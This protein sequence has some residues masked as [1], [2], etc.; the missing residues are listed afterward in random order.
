[1]SLVGKEEQ[2]P[3]HGGDYNEEAPEDMRGEHRG[4]RKSAE[5]KSSVYRLCVRVVCSEIKK[6]TPGSVVDL[7]L[8][9]KGGR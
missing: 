2:A 6:N 3:R 8:R 4:D 5:T 9:F 7:R 1:M